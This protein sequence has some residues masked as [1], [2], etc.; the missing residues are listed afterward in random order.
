MWC[1]T[2]SAW[3]GPGDDLSVPRYEEP[4]PTQAETSQIHR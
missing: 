1:T 3:V 4:G 2:V